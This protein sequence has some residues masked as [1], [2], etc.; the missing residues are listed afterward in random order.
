MCAHVRCFSW[1]TRILVF[2][3]DLDALEKVV[4]SCCFINYRKSIFHSETRTRKM[5]ELESL[6]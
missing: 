6:E 1:P 2:V 5:E 3:S 4:V